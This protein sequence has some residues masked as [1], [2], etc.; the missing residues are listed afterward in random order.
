MTSGMRVKKTYLKSS[1]VKT[2][3]AQSWRC[4]MISSTSPSDASAHEVSRRAW[5]RREAGHTVEIDL[6][7]KVRV[8]EDLHGDLLL[9][10]VLCLEFGVLDGDVFLDV[11]ARKLDLLVLAGAVHAHRGPVRDGDGDTEKND[12]EDVCLEAAMAEDRQSALDEPWD[13]EDEGGEVE[14]VEGAVALCEA[15]EGRVLD[16]GCVCLC[17]GEGGHVHAGRRDGAGHGGGGG[18]GDGVECLLVAR[19]RCQ[20]PDATPV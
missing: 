7:L 3:L 10:K 15:D 11:T 13:A 1:S 18:G 17:D 6:A 19:C 12:K 5:T 20:S 2:I 4:S 8:V 16:G 9:A 14:V